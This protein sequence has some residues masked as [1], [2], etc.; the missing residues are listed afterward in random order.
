M[1]RKSGSLLGISLGVIAIA[2]AVVWGPCAAAPDYRIVHDADSG[3][4]FVLFKDGTDIPCHNIVRLYD[5]EEPFHGRVYAAKELARKIRA[6]TFNS[7]EMSGAQAEG[8]Y[9]AC[10]AESDHAAN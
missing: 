1:S 4:A 8:L 2:I 10:N 9:T 3:A 5:I 6:G 7:I